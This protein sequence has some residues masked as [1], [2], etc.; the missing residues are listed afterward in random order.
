MEPGQRAVDPKT[1]YG[2]DVGLGGPDLVRRTRTAPP[3]RF[4][5]N[6]RCADRARIRRITCAAIAKKCARFCHSTRLIDQLQV[7]LV[8]ETRGLSTLPAVRA[9]CDARRSRGARRTRAGPGDRARRARQPRHSRRSRVMSADG[10][11]ARWFMGRGG[12]VTPGT[13]PGGLILPWGYRP[14]TMSPVFLKRRV[15]G[16]LEEFERASGARHE[17]HGMPDMCRIRCDR[18][19]AAGAWAGT[20]CSRGIAFSSARDGNNEIYVMDWDGA[21]PSPYR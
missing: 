6:R 2:I 9:P 1:S 20:R 5:R 4:P 21:G 12:A 15:N 18:R 17:K 11:W 19:A 7:G 13:G 3:P 16:W 8:H 14:H 10:S